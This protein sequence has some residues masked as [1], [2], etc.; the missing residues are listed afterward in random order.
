MK[1][2]TVLGDSKPHLSDYMCDQSHASY[3]SKVLR[4]AMYGV[5]PHVIAGKDGIGG[6]DI[7]LLDYLTAKLEFTSKIY[8][9]KSWVSSINTVC[10]KTY[11]TDSYKKIRRFLKFSV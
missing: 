3:K 5:P 9:A 4:V 1:Y 6:A 10:Y 2:T 8:I 11:F 7:K